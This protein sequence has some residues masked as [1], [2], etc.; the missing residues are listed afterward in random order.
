MGSGCLVI[1]YLPG[2][3]KSLNSTPRTG[4][5]KKKRN[6]WVREE[7]EDK[8]DREMG[9]TVEKKGMSAVINF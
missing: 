7:K 8:R 2:M 5:G 6:M 3:C 1:V 9:T 4:K